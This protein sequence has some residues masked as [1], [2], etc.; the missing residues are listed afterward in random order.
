LDNDD[1]KE[2]KSHMLGLLDHCDLQPTVLFRIAI[3]EIEAFYLGDRRAIRQAYPKAK[4][5]KS[6]SYIQ[7]SIC[8][9][10][11]VFQNVIGAYSES[12]VEWA[13]RIGEHLTTEWKGPNA[14]RSKSFQNLCKAILKLIGELAE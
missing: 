10:W 14:N 2:L 3:E 7:D 6:E 12:K 11:E 8:G 1:C 13:R 4:L 5:Y 9:T